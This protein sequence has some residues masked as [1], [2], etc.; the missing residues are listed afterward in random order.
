M[1]LEY[2]RRAIYTVLSEVVSEKKL[3][4]VMWHW[5]NTYSDK[6][7]FE[8]NK[9]LSD[10]NSIPEIANRRSELYRKIIVLLVTKNMELKN[11]PWPLM[12]D[13]HKD[14]IN[15]ISSVA[16]DNWSEIFTMV[17][18]ELFSRLNL[19]TQRSVSHYVI[20]NLVKLKLP[21]SLVYSFHTWTDQ[22]NNINAQEADR[23]QLKKLLNLIYIAICELIGPVKADQFLSDS[24]KKAYSFHNDS[25]LDARLLL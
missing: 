17:M 9:F 12:L 19:D 14:K 21:N 5:Q 6:S 23:T 15:N 3:L 18:T 2:K 4:D 22:R 25:D 16:S 1:I 13:Y 20:Q 7:Q 10:C 8:L 24:I 11:D